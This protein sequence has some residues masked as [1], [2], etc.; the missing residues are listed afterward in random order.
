MG[1]PALMGGMNAGAP[2]PAVIPDHR[3][4][5]Q[6]YLY[7]PG[8]EKHTRSAE[9]GRIDDS[10]A[11]AA[12]KGKRDFIL[13]EPLDNAVRERQRIVIVTVLGAP[14][15]EIGRAQVYMASSLARWLSEQKT[16]DCRLS[17]SRRA[18]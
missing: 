16:E 12:C 17:I 6:V 2:P 9:V 7:G 4:E 14:R 18:S 15:S 1:L 5:L 11:T 8:A 10:L 13:F 3:Q